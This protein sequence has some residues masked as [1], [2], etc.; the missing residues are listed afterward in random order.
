MSDQTLFGIITTI[1]QTGA[2]T[3]VIVS[4]IRLM[5]KEKTV[6]LPFMFVLA[7]ASYL[8]SDLYWIAYDILKPDTRMPIACN[9]IG[10]CAIILLLS[11][12][13][14]SLLV[15][16]KK[17]AGEIVFAFLFIGANIALWIAWSGEWFQDIL[18]GIPYIYFMWILIRGLRGRGCMTTKEFWIASVAGVFV[19]IVQIPLFV[20]KGNLFFLSEIIGFG[21]MFAIMAWLGVKSFRSK[22]CFVTATFFL[23]TELSMFL[24]PD[25]YYNLAMLANTIS[26]FFMFFSMKKEIA[27]DL[28]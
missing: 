18:F 21:M 7:M 3:V 11:A 13:L 1:L 8:L 12:G 2:L 26:C 20:V 9:E 28:C 23:W 14:E 5:L 10:E 27:N 17:I 6:F 16:K 15:D 25:I 19:L 4:T 24:T 22:D